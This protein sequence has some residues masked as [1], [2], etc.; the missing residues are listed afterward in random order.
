MKVTPTSLPEVKLLEN[1]V[2]ADN[3]GEFQVAY[4]ADQF[5]AA[6]IAE[7]FVQHNLSRSRQGVL[8]G[9][10]LQHP[11]GQGKLVRVLEGEVFD[12]AVDVRVGSPNFGR[13]MGHTL[14]GTSGQQLYIPQGF[15]HGF[16]VTS[17]EALVEYKCTAYHDPRTERSVSWCDP[18]IG[19]AWPLTSEP[20][21][22]DKDRLAGPLAALTSLLPRYE[23]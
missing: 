17:V 13:W 5:A 19:V 10:H 6:G 20:V 9:L 22:S 3:R 15:A 8:R 14:S 18:D 1:D 11:N 2:F 7:S 12:V 4:R 21:L 16:V 23:P